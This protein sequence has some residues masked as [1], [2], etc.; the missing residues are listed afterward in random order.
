MVGFLLRAAITA[1]AC[2][3]ERT[4]VRHHLRCPSKLILAAIVL[5]VVTRGAPLAFILT[6]RSRWSRSA[7]SC[8]C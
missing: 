3:R 2:G 7:C 4:V 5:G 6:L 1:L 8:S